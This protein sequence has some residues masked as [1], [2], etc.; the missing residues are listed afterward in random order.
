LLNLSHRAYGYHPGRYVLLA[1]LVSAAVVA[2]CDSDERRAAEEKGTELSPTEASERASRTPL[3]LT[4]VPRAGHRTSIIRIGF[5]TPIRIGTAAGNRRRGY[6]L[7]ARRRGGMSGCVQQRD[8][9]VRPG[10][11]GQRVV[12]RINP[13]RGKGGLLGWCRGEYRGKVRYYDLWACP[14]TEVCAEPDRF[15]SID[16]VVARFRFSIE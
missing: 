12:G 15:E 14:D 7:V 8:G 9:F 4:V 16:Q 13:A 11:A 10:R 3:E 2:G 1:A 5:K 6:F